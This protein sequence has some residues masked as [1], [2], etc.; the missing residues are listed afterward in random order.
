[1]LLRGLQCIVFTITTWHFYP[2]LLVFQ[3][4]PVV[5]VPESLLSEDSLSGS[6]VGEEEEGV[7]SD[8]GTEILSE[9]D[10]KM[11]VNNN[12]NHFN[13]YCRED[14]GS[15][16]LTN[17]FAQSMEYKSLRSKCCDTYVSLPRRCSRG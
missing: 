11:K 7:V 10:D 5:S 9:S 2:C 1:M 4:N 12:C 14:C 8:P 13:H 3:Q 17:Q 15:F 16:K 6:M